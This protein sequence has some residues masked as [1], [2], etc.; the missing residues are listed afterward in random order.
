MARLTPYIVVRDAPRAIAFYERAFGAHELFRLTEPR[1]TRIGHAEMTIGDSLLYVA[2][3][4]PDF[5]A[6][7]PASIGGTP[8]T[9]HLAVDDADA[10][11]Q[12]AEAA[13]AT[14]LRPIKDEFFGDRTGMVADP[15]GHKWQISAKKEDVSP[16][17]MQERWNAA[18]A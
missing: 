10:V 6:L 9:L 16:S 12:Q 11:M 17:E 1:S 18:M 8:V 14:V 15:F 13:G 4:W 2:D 5:G 7:S 3:E